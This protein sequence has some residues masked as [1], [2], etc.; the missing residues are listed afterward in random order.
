MRL[1]FL[2]LRLCYIFYLF[3]NR[4]EK[5]ELKGF[6]FRRFRRRNGRFFTCRS[7]FFLIYL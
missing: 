5:G 7:L 2:C 3:L 6:R 4:W 1:L